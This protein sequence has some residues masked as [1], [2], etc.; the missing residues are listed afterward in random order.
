MWEFLRRLDQT[1]HI[2]I[3]VLAGH[4][5]WIGEEGALRGARI[6][7]DQKVVRD[8]SAW[9]RVSRRRPAARSQREAEGE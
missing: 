5:V 1:S 3:G 2:K 8:M 6:P 9:S 4:L 7:I